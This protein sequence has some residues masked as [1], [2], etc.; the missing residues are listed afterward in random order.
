MGISNELLAQAADG[1][2][3]IEHRTEE[4]RSVCHFLEES[5]QGALSEEEEN[6]VFSA[7]CRKIDIAGSVW[8]I[9]DS[10]WK[11]PLQKIPLP[12]DYTTLLVALFLHRAERT[13]NI[14]WR[15][16]LLNSAF[17]ILSKKTSGGLWNDLYGLATKLLKAGDTN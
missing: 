6:Q 3:R 15:Y 9:Y 13:I 7:L 2:H 17:N 8:T 14:G 5:L 12:E 11:K 4:G 16:K 10:D 1:L